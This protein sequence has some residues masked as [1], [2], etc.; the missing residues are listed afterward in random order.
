EIR[1][2]AAP[3][4]EWYIEK[5]LGKLAQTEQPRWQ[6]YVWLPQQAVTDSNALIKKSEVINISEYMR[7]DGTIRWKVPPGEWL[8]IRYGMLP[9]GV[10]NFPATPEATG[11]EMDK[12]SQSPIPHHFS[13]FIGKIR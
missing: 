13:S 8:I 9:T 4:L 2:G 11:L 5:Q 6:D 7:E 1:I 3:K 12:L 10:V